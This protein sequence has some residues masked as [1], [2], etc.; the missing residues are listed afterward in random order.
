MR[1]FEI[2]TPEAN[3]PASRLQPK[4]RRAASIQKDSECIPSD[5]DAVVAKV[6]RFG[7]AGRCF[8]QSVHIFVPGLKFSRNHNALLS[9][10][11][12][13]IVF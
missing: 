9:T 1:A 3:R 8:K 10:S 7:F 12:R 6:K 11:P 4:R 5:P 13:L 2:I